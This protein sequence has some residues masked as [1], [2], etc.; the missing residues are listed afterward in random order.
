[1]A[2]AINDKQ[3]DRLSAAFLNIFTSR[4]NKRKE[5]IVYQKSAVSFS[6][7]TIA[8]ITPLEVLRL[9]PGQFLVHNVFTSGP[10]IPKIQIGI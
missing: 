7:P 10:A 8:S 3:Q 9:Q 6:N 5:Q 1:L 4:V 2:L